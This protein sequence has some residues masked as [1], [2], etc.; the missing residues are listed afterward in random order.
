METSPKEMVPEPMEW[1]AMAVRL[2][3]V[4]PGPLCSKSPMATAPDRGEPPA[5]GRGIVPDPLGGERPPPL[6]AYRKKR[7]P[8][9][10]PEPFG[11]RPPAGGR[12]FVVHKHAA[13]RLHFDLRLE[14]DGVLRSWAVPKGPSANP[15]D[16][17]LA[18]LVEDHP[19]EYGDFEGKIPEG[20]Y[21]AGA[22]IVWDRGRWRPIGDPAEGLK[23][24]KLLF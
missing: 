20:N 7:D 22:V 2:C 11:G 21:G 17:R 10:T 19:L 23:K 18:V 15:A 1:G 14:M 12:L 6:E 3:T 24:G 4:P 8:D 9:R 13:R 16:K 5:K